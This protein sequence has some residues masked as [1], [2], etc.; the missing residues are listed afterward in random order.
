MGPQNK[1]PVGSERRQHL[2]LRVIYAEAR[3]HIDHLFHHRHDW[4]GSSID[5]LAQRVIH[6][7]YPH[8]RGEDVRTLVDAIE[9]AHQPHP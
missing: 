3:T 9:R 4:A 6:E 2:Q 1:T 5:F 8:L 7:A